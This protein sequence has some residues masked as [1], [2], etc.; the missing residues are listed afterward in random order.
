M[1]R[2]RAVL[3]A[4]SA[5]CD[6]L[7]L[8]TVVEGVET[9]EHLRAVKEANI[10]TVQGYYFSRPQSPQDLAVWLGRAKP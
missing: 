2:A 1:N 4:I 8:D 3:N 7:G 10:G 9:D 5:I 6:Q